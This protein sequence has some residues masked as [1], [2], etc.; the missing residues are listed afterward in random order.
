MNFTIASVDDISREVSYS[1]VQDG[2][3]YV[4]AAH[5]YKDGKNV[6]RQFDELTDAYK[7]FEK[8]VSWIFFGLYADNDR[9]DFIEKGTME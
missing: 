1:I 5:R 6:S 2:N 4:V 9:M 8:I 7:M 3:K